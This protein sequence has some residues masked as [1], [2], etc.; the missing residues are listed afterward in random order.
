MRCGSVSLWGQLVE[1]VLF[2]ASPSAA[3]AVYGY[4]PYYGYYGHFYGGYHGGYGGGGGHR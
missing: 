2:T 3:V 1:A 4:Y